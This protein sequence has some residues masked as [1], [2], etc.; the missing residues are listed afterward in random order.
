MAPNRIRVIHEETTSLLDF[1]YRNR[2]TTMAP[3]TNRCRISCREITMG[4]SQKASF[5]FEIA[6]LS[7]RDRLRKLCIYIYRKKDKSTRDS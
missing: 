5:A 2:P 3:L 4:F 7:T 6:I 1:L